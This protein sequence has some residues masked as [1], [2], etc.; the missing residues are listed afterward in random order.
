MDF[1]GDSKK[2]SFVETDQERVD[3]LAFQVEARVT[4]CVK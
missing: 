2:K 1:L 4:W 3:S